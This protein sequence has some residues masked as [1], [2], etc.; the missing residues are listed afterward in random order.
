MKFADLKR[1][2]GS[3]IKDKRA[4]MGFS[5]EE[6]AHRAGLNRTYVSNVERG[7]RNPSLECIERLAGALE[8][9][10]S[11]LFARVGGD[12]APEGV[13]VLLVEDREEDVR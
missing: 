13:E 7:A 5:Q 2:F 6:L 3:A 11:G 12:L 1:T 8:V 4:E 9:S 10:I